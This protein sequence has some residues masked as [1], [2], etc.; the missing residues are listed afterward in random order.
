[1]PLSSHPSH[2][3]SELVEIPF[4][5]PISSHKKFSPTFV[6]GR[7]PRVVYSRS[8][9]DLTGNAISPLIRK[10]RVNFMFRLTTPRK[11]F[12]V[13]YAL[14]TH[15]SV[16]V[17]EKVLRWLRGAISQHAK[18]LCGYDIQLC[19]YSNCPTISAFLTYILP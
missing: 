18:R 2:L 3:H 9:F 12:K 4:S 14:D 13:I 7:Q 17:K 11:F 1:M 16:M 15:Y 19:R 8:L 6:N 5:V 10:I